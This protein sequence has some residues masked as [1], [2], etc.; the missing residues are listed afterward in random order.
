MQLKQKFLT[1]EQVD[2]FKDQLAELLQEVKDN[3]PSSLLSTAKQN[4]DD[5]MP[6]N[7][8]SDVTLMPQPNV[9]TSNA[10]LTDL[11]T[12]FGAKHLEKAL[13]SLQTTKGG[14]ATVPG[15]KT[16]P[17]SPNVSMGSL[18]T[19]PSSDAEY[20]TPLGSPDES[21]RSSVATSSAFVSWALSQVLREILDL[22]RN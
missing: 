17:G 15:G 19:E 3:P 12:L 14:E 20:Y 21:R 2:L 11:K 10:G 13:Q 4:E 6:E 22:V 5:V 8:E 16:K 1:K 9:S 18:G 7:P